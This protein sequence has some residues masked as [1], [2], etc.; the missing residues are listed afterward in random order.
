[1]SV[2]AEIKLITSDVDGTLLDSKQR[3]TDKVEKAVA[4]SRSVGV[5][6]SIPKCTHLTESYP[7]VHLSGTFMSLT[8]TSS[9][10]IHLEMGER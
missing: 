3:L 2:R 7:H 4:L 5:P 6:V 9:Q 10:F 8:A 1:M